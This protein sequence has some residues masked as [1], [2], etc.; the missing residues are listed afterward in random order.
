MKYQALNTQRTLLAALVLA[1]P[2]LAAA[3][4]A[5]RPSA[6][7]ILQEL[8]PVTPVAPA[9][10]GTG[11]TI[12]REQ[13]ASAPAGAPFTVKTIQ[14]KGNTLFDAA[15]LH[16]LVADA[17]GKTQTLA[18]LEKIVARITDYYQNRGY[19]LTQAIIPAQTISDAVVE[20]QVIEAHYGD[21]TLEN[22]AGANSDLLLSTLKPL[23]KGLD[24]SK[25]Q[26]DQSLLLLSDIPGVVVNATLNK[27]AEVGTADLRVV[28][29]AAPAVVGNVMVDGY[30]NS[31][32]GKVRTSGTVNI[33]GPFNQGDVLSLSGMSSGSGMNYGRVGYESVLNG[34]GTRVGGAYSALRY[35]LGGSLAALQSHGT[36]Q[37]QSVFVKQPL[38]RSRDTN[39]Y[40]TVQYDRLKLSDR[41]DVSAI[42]TD[43][44]LG[45]L[46]LS[47]AGDARN[48]LMADGV[49]SW[50]LGWKT[51]RVS[52][53]N[54]I[55][56]LADAATAKTQGGFSKLNANVAHV[57]SLSTRSSLYFSLTG[58]WANN[59]LDASEKMVAGGP[60]SVRAYDV[61]ALSGDSGYLM[62]AEY[63]YDLGAFAKGQ[64]QAV[65]FVDS[66][67]VTVNKT[68]WT[69][70]INTANL[71]GVGVGLNWTGQDQW[72]AKLSTAAR[73]GTVSPLIAA[74]TG[75]VRTWAE[76]S[77]GF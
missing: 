71:S 11:L 69:S 43:R 2:G 22:N 63:R 49:T 27:G 44:S 35:V 20:V 76:V 38:V 29:T 34:Q 61:G 65:V 31:Y 39:V 55:A 4:A 56:K 14:I 67:N 66:A 64:T 3:Q 68:T 18:Q 24:I 26:M 53:E 32:T 21:I 50:S 37:V 54:A 46:T 9:S 59:N 5:P 42:Q 47:L 57:Q 23:K 10:S 70:S 25:A 15:T 28:A 7:S 17:E 40:G 75:S 36:A 13:A 52:F 48:A 12:Q 6:G 41:I 58:Q 51:G 8:Q 19:P 77:K 62:T 73:V 60:Y 1:L 74:N 45:N 33:N 72:R 30:G 16:E